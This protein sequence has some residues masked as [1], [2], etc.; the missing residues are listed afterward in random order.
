MPSR[1]EGLPVELPSGG[2][3]W[4]TRRS[5]H[6]RRAKQVF[7]DWS[8]L[9]LCRRHRVR[10]SASRRLGWQRGG[11]RQR[12]WWC[13]CDFG[14]AKRRDDLED[15]RCSC[16]VVGTALVAGAGARARC[17]RAQRAP[18]R[19]ATSA[20]ATMFF[21]TSRKRRIVSTCWG[22]DVTQQAQQAGGRTGDARERERLGSEAQTSLWILAQQQREGDKN[23]TE[24]LEL[25]TA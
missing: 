5:R 24:T 21:A 13:R 8:L 16:S 2:W 9:S 12:R 18:R 25:K 6:W 17:S 7:Q 4:R 20:G 11:G 23:P 10:G 19:G 1:R 3:L 15:I 14:R 22:G